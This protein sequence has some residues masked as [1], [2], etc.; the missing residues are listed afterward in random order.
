MNIQKTERSGMCRLPIRGH[1]QYGEI[2]QVIGPEAEQHLSQSL[3]KDA[4]GHYVFLLEYVYNDEIPPIRPEQ[5]E[6]WHRD[7]WE[8]NRIDHINRVKSSSRKMDEAWVAAQLQDLRFHRGQAIAE[9]ILIL[10]S[11]FTRHDFF[12][13]KLEKSW[14]IPFEGSRTPVWGQTHPPSHNLDISKAE[15]TAHYGDAIPFEETRDHFGRPR[16]AYIVGSEE[17]QVTL[18]GNLPSLFD[19]YFG[20]IEAKKKLFYP[21]CR[22][23]YQAC[24]I[25]NESP[26]VS[27]LAAVSAIALCVNESETLTP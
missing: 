16:D 18:P 2:F 12:Y 25:R 4:P 13:Y 3:A 1:F 23:Y 11:T 14:F 9:E 15:F 26:S 19:T 8:R 27:L 10:M 17:N 20:L 5:S 7:L 21:A 22:L 24:Q 6:M